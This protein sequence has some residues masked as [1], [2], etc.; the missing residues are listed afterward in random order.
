MTVDWISLIIGTSTSE[1]NKFY[2]Y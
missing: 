1:Q 2:K